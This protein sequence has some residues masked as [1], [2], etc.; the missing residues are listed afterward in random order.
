MHILYLIIL[1]MLLRKH[2]YVNK[3]I[4]KKIVVKQPLHCSSPKLEM[5][6][7]CNGKRS[8]AIYI[9]MAKKEG[10]SSVCLHSIAVHHKRM[11]L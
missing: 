5:T 11:F 7:M 9:F 2:I 4:C 8:C 3:K 1:I 10:T 6:Q